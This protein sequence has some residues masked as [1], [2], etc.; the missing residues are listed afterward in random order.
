[1][2]RLGRFRGKGLVFLQ[3]AMVLGS[4]LAALWIRRLVATD[5][6]SDAMAIV[7]E[8]AGFAGFLATAAICIVPA[9]RAAGGWQ[10]TYS[11]L[12][13]IAVVV[14]GA[15]FVTASYAD[16]SIA[17]HTVTTRV[18]LAPTTI[19]LGPDGRD[20]RL[21]G[22]L[23][24]GAARR[25]AAILAAHPQ[26]ERIHLTSDG[27]LVDE[28]EAMRKIIGSRRLTTF[29]PDFCVSA[30]TLAFLGGHERLIMTGARL[31]F[32]SPYE[33]GLFGQT[34]A[35]DTS[36]ERTAYVSAGVSPDFVDRAFKVAPSDIWTPDPDLLTEARIIT[37]VVD[38][39]RFPDSNLDGIDNPAG[40]RTTVLRSFPLAKA[41]D[42]NVLDAIAGAYLA[43]YREGLSEGEVIDGLRSVVAAAATNVIAKADD[44]TMVRFGRFLDEA[45]RAA[46]SEADC[47][48]I[49]STADLLQAQEALDHGDGKADQAAMSL[50]SSALRTGRSVGRSAAAPL[51]P[52]E[53]PTALKRSGGACTA[54]RDIY[55]SALRLPSHAAAE[56]IRAF[57]VRSMQP[58]ATLSMI[59]H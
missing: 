17:I 46:A 23:A 18:D 15:T 19:V 45:M 42:S 51:P 20:V 52:Q 27:G 25:L 5:A 32:H 6:V 58:R 35:G 56:Q 3:G 26:I 40:A 11:R 37:G 30:C 8:L 33:E 59:A 31:G 43:A 12:S 48:A 9:V 4:C 47:V 50:V 54:I 24:E 49:G 28:G 16:V 14:A 22:S 39:Y 7:L 41:L 53:T 34:F 38:R 2:M 44:D 36:A 21:S 57:A 13:A 10:R 29:V 1:M 55:E